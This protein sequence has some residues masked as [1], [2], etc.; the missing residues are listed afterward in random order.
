[1]S[2]PLLQVES[3][4]VDY[5]GPS[6][7]VE[8]L[9]F[10]LEA[11]GTLGLVGESG[12]GKSTVALALLRLLGPAGRIC[13]GRIRFD[14][15]DLHAL[16]EAAMRGV[17]G[18]RIGMIFQEPMSSLHPAQRV[19]AQVAEGLRV[20]QRLGRREALER[21]VELLDQVGIVHAGR[22]AAS[23]PHQLSGGQRQRVMIAQAIACSPQLLIADEPTTALDASTR[24]QVMDLIGELQARY[25]MALLLISHDLGMIAARAGRILVMRGGREVEQGDTAAVLA[26][27]RQAYTRQLIASRPQP[28]SLLDRLP[29]DGAAPVPA[30]PPTVAA[31][32][33][34]LLEV[35]E[36]VVRHRAARGWRSAATSAAVDR[37]SF[38]LA[39]GRT[40]GLLGESGSGKTTLARAVLR[41]IEADA[42][43]LHFDGVDLR[44]QSGGR[45][46]RMRRRMQIVFQDPFASLNPRMS[47][48]DALCE[49]LRVHGLARG[50]AAAEARAVELLQ[51]VGLDRDALER[52][53][54]AFSGGQRQRIG[55]AR[56][57]AVEPELIVCDESVSALDL[58][59][60][61]Q[62]LNLLR[63]LQDRLGLAYLFISHD[64]DVIR[65]M[66]DRIAVMRAGRLVEIG[67]AEQVC[68]APR[69][70][71]TRS[72]LA[73]R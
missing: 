63:D 44:A 48:R 45:L 57:L 8:G 49:P 11:G 53:P 73:D 47:V 41:L 50:R 19:G 65:F 56:S 58:S 26:A 24:R 52:Y 18:R 69:H 35:R 6:L 25:G 43:S 55:I 59:V 36:L 4:G 61:A 5:G 42:G 34:V 31:E 40:L 72:L 64:I 30:A 66:A 27:P 23:Y 29:V 70:P 68:N 60:Q 20:H 2:E 13:S 17:R 51:Q 12:S 3:L 7:A 14:G 67:D 33:S 32:P 9:D 16:P 15:L 46:R 22:N 10:S 1:M 54:H 39:R 62:V 21:A 28:R 71:Y 38:S 37:V